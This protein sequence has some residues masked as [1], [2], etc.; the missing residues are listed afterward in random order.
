MPSFELGAFL[1]ALLLAHAG[2]SL[3]RRLR[4][5]RLEREPRQQER[6]RSEYALQLA[7]IGSLLLYSLVRS[8]GGVLADRGHP[9]TK[10]LDGWI[11]LAIEIAGSA[12]V[13][14]LWIAPIAIGLHQHR[15]RAARAAGILGV[16]FWFFLAL[17]LNGSR[18]T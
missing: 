6:S 1:A 2:P 14:P 3:W 17:V 5:R 15:F 4:A 10:S 18:V 16:W 11:Q 8:Y 13:F 7:A 9:Y 12:M